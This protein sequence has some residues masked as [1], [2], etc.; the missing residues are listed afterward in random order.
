MYSERSGLCF[1]INYQHIVI[2]QY[3]RD[4]GL[5]CPSGSMH[6]NKEHTRLIYGR[7]S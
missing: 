5:R 3:G 4:D 1:I 6:S 7:E 2:T